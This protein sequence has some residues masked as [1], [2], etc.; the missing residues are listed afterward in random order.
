M[1]DDEPLPAKVVVVDV[2]GR[3]D[4]G[5]V[6]EHNEDSY[7]VL[8]LDSGS[9]DEK[10]LL[11]HE[12]GPR[13]T[14]MV[15]CDGMGGAAA[16]EVASSMAIE[17]VAE[18]M[19]IEGKVAPPE[20]TVDDELTA[21][22]RK[23]REAAREANGRIFR[24]ARQNLAR[25]GMGTTMTA[26]LLDGIHAVIAQVGDSRAYVYRKGDFTQV[27][28]DQSLVNQL[29]ETG[30]ITPDQARFFEH[31][32]VILQALGV[33]EEVEVQLSRVE[34]R[35]GD[36]ILL[37]SDGLVGVVSDDEIAA[38]LG[39]V[40]EL[41]DA[42][43]ML[44][45]LA[46]AAGG[47]DNIT[48]VLARVGGGGLVEPAE[49][50]ALEYK[51]WKI[52][53]EPPPSATD[54]QDT[55][56]MPSPTRNDLRVVP[57]RP[58]RNPMLELISMA[59]VAGLLLGG[60]LTAAAVYRGRVPCVIESPVAGFAI[61]VDGQDTGRLTTSGALPLRLRPGRHTLE[62]RGATS[63]GVAAPADPIE[64]DVARDRMCTLDF[65]PQP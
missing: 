3:S 11:R 43:R 36:V 13:G 60:L 4:V 54:S 20:G 5:Q 32:N 64:V 62:L 61:V 34:L 33:Q 17:S 38:V 55:D 45:E 6:R 28:R 27:T 7:V 53:P 19:L 47:P 23:L 29:L 51:L 10:D 1:A 49:S 50:D 58:K 65:G 16:G 59:V 57:R 14:L 25:S 26:A 40:D 63:S 37:C 8:R 41:A 42:A 12:L 24:E 39:S 52:D 18:Q 44:T 30:H 15:V 56:P 46:N 35:L 48:V 9:R 21:L 31:S 2:V 22:G